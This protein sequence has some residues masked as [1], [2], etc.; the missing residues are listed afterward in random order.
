MYPDVCSFHSCHL[1]HE[2]V[3]CKLLFQPWFRTGS[4][5]TFP[6]E[7]IL[8]DGDLLQRGFRLLRGWELGCC[9]WFCQ[10]P[11]DGFADVCVL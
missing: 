2:S 6:F 9:R 1:L 5:A 7:S 8:H 3:Y 4:K 10:F 11:T